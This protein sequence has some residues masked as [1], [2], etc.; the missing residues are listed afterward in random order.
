MNLNTDFAAGMKGKCIL[1]IS[2]IINFKNFKTRNAI[3]LSQKDQRHKKRR[4]PLYYFQY[5]TSNTIVLKQ[6]VRVKVQE[7]KAI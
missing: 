6:S 3:K 1:Y 2:G 4:S 7:K 5:I